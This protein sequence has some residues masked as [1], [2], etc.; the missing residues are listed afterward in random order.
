ML[1]AE[2]IKNNKHDLCSGLLSVA[3]KN[4]MIKIKFK[5]LGLER[6]LHG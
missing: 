4:T 2:G 1:D 5:E 3:V 6:G